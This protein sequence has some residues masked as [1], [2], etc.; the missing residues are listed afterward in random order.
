MDVYRHIVLYYILQVGFFFFFNKLK[1]CGSPVLSKSINVSFPTACVYFLS[2]S[3]FCNS[4][5]I[6]GLFF[7]ICYGNL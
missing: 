6:S 1:V 2:V 7:S 5:N 4:C 3:H